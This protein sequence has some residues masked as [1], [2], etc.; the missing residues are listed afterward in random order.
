MLYLTYKVRQNLRDAK[1]IYGYKNSGWMQ[2][3][4]SA[5]GDQIARLYIAKSTVHD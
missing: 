3:S 5:P 4:Y 1:F 2:N